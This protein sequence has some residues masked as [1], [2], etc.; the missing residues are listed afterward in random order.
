MPEK[1]TFAPRNTL[2]S[3]EQIK[4]VTQAFVEL[5]IKK[6]R[7]T[8]A[9]PLIHPEFAHIVNYLNELNGLEN[10]ALTTNGSKIDIS[11]KTLEL[12]KVKQVNISLD[13]LDPATFSSITRQKPEHLQSV[14]NGIKTASQIDNLRVRLN[15]V[16]M[17]GVN[18][19]EIPAMIDFA[20][21]NQCHIAFIEEMPLG[22][23]ALFDREE[24]TIT[25]KEVLSRIQKVHTL[26]PLIQKNTLRGPAN[27]YRING[28]KSEVGFISPHSN[29]FC[30]Q[31]NRVRLTRS[32][33]LILCL[34]N[35]DAVDLKHIIETST[36]PLESVKAAITSAMTQKPESHTFDNASET[37]VIRFM[38]VTGG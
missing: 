18:D 14:I 36:T 27:Y 15:V 24:R 16:V 23:N 25:N 30:H 7:L 3:F 34:G 26:T 2:L 10:I 31:C 28:T 21:A 19:H 20:I 33:K 11:V 5:G 4:I 17:R 1:M 6:I 13:S 22:E 35:N 29:N 37:Q 9:E 8:G 12:S 38:N 32:G